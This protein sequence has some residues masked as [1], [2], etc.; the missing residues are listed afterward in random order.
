MTHETP[1]E[2]WLRKYT[3]ERDT[4]IDANAYNPADEKDSCGVGLVAQIDGTPRREI[5]EMAIRALKAV[6]HRGAIDADGKTGDGAGIRVDVPQDFF[7]D[8]VRGMGH[9]IG[10][11]KQV[12]VGQ[13]FLPRTDL[14][15]QEKARS[16]IET[17]VVRFGFYIYGWRQP[18]IDT[19]VIGMKANATRPEIEQILFTDQLRRDP[20]ELERALYV[21][22]R[23]IE[24]RA[25]E[26][27]ATSISAR[28]PAC[29]DLQGHVPRR[30]YRQLLS[31]LERPALRFGGRNLSPALFDQHLPA[32]AAGPALPHARAQWRDQH[33][34]GQHQLDEEPRDQDGLGR[35]RR[36]RRRCET[37][38]PAGR[39]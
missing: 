27:K 31:R 6:F 24:K 12:C 38:D 26:A 23:R 20:P 9:A 1:G 25:R 21:C 39:V 30:G 7:R 11:D 3:T 17:E 37:R 16:I 2:R 15:A 35:V 18:P 28:S 5:V 4:L 32:M 34:L 36:A 33:H 29:P 10:G 13:I 14:A 22:R 19:S 8:A